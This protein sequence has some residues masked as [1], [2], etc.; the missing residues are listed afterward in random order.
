MWFKKRESTDVEKMVG[1]ERTTYS[2][3][4][5]VLLWSNDRARSA[6]PDPCNGFSSC[7]SEMLHQVATNEGACSAKA[8]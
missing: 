2:L 6:D 8:S 1:N 5:K 7:K 3:F 4:H